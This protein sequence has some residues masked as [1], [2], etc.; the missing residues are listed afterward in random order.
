ME[1]KV[2]IKSLS[3]HR[4]VL[5]VP[6]MRLTRVW[7][8]KGTIRTIPFEQLEEAFYNPGVE[9]L[10]R[11]GVLGIDDMDVKKRLGL[12]PEDVD[13]PTNLISLTDEEMKKLLTEA[14]VHEFRAKLKELPIEQI[15]ELI[16]YAIEHEIAH[17][18]KS[19]ILRGITGIDI[20]SAIRLNRDDLAA[21]KEE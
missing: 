13:E 4:V 2:R 7:E 20:I 17:F 15:N 16:G 12:E 6:D 14:P 8:K 19:E 18:D 1:N 5:T 3:S 11:N 21:Q 9:A 10:F